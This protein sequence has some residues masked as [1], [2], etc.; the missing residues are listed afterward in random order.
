MRHSVSGRRLQKLYVLVMGLLG[1]G[2]STFISV[3]TGNDKIPIGAATDIDGGKCMVNSVFTC[4]P[5]RRAD[6]SSHSRSTGL[7][8]VI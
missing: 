3:I 8:A 6:L 5:Q 7:R 2:K 4:C 1:A